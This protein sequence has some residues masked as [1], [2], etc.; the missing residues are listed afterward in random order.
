MSNTASVG[1][2]RPGTR[3]KS[4]DPRDNGK[5]IVVTDIGQDGLDLYAIYQTGRRIAKIRFTRIFTDGLT[6]AQGYNV[7]SP[8]S[9]GVS[10][11]V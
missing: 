9:G 3:L 11:I 6:R 10:S 7:E 1:Q 2:V 5:I 4:N 8:L